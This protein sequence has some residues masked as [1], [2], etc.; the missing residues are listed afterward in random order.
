MS[1]LDA[2]SDEFISEE[3]VPTDAGF[4]ERALLDR[5]DN[6]VGSIP[7]LNYSISLRYE[8]NGPAGTFIPNISMSYRDEMFVG[9]DYD[10]AKHA[11]TTLNDFTLFNAHM[12]YIPNGWDEFEITLF[13]DN[14]TDEDYFDGGF[15]TTSNIPATIAS[16]GAP[17]TYGMG[18]N[19][20]F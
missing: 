9:I 5:S 7:P 1:Y 19:Y 3:V 17:R 10:S 15:A 16:K 2:S 4:P 20:Y 8:M 14:I 11:E 13:V 18:L 6:D 12:R